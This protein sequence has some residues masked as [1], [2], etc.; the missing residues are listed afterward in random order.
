M[1]LHGHFVA[2]TTW[3]NLGALAAADAQLATKTRYFEELLISVPDGAY[4][5]LLVA[6]RD[7]DAVAPPSDSTANTLAVGMSR[8]YLQTH[9]DKIW[10]KVASGVTGV[11]EYSGEAVFDVHER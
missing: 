11:I 8:S 7:F 9:L 1:E 2:T 10:F 4:P 3:Q 6:I 5:A